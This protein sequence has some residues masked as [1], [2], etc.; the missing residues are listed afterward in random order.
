MAFTRPVMTNIPIKFQMALVS[1]CCHMTLCH[2]LLGTLKP[3]R[4]GSS[5]LL[6][7]PLKVYLTSFLSFHSLFLCSY[8][9]DSSPSLICRNPSNLLIFPFLSIALSNFHYDGTE[10]PFDLFWTYEI[11]LSEGVLNTQLGN[12]GMLEQ[13]TKRHKCLGLRELSSQNG[14]WNWL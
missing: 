8:V 5:D 6:L 14:T 11:N 12:T 10:V 4:W 2:P 1:H 9:F 7:L 13:T 3:L